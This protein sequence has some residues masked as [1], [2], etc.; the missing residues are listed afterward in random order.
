MALRLK[1]AVA[2]SIPVTNAELWSQYNVDTVLGGLGAGGVQGIQGVSGNPYAQSV[3]GLNSENDR[4]REQIAQLKTQIPNP[5]SVLTPRQQ[6]LVQ[7]VR[8]MVIGGG[9]EY[10]KTVME[11][12]KA[13]AQA[14]LAGAMVEV[15][16]Q[17]ALIAEVIERS[18]DVR[19][20]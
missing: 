2:P 18:T 20:K 15:G 14:K 6:G 5:E 13:D 17:L 19:H 12:F 3:S 10:T 4:L 7:E 1:K 8:R 9:Q 16:S 11:M